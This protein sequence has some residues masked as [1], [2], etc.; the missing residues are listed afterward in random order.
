MHVGMS[1]PG[2]SPGLDGIPPRRRRRRRF[3][4]PVV[5]LVVV[6]IAA[7]M[8]VRSRTPG[9]T[10]AGATPGPGNASAGATPSARGSG[11]TGKPGVKR[12]PLTVAG[13]FPKTKLDVAGLQFTQVAASTTTDCPTAAQ[14]KFAAALSSAHCRR[15]VRATYVD[16][17]KQ[18]VVTAGVAVLPTHADAASADGAKQFVH[19]VW[20]TALNGPASSGAGSASQS[21]GMGDDVVDYRFIVFALSSYTSGHNPTGH[22]SEI[23]TLTGLSQAF[24]GDAEKQ[25]VSRGGQA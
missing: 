5:V 11:A 14:G 7:I 19:D 24:C 9:N 23:K 17:H 4:G 25:L 10:T 6:L 22:T 15:V 8:I 20:F 1:G 3:W 16:T 13:I 21:V 18:Y 12:T 2:A